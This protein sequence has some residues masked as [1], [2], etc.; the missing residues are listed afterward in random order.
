MRMNQVRCTGMLALALLG[1]SVSAKADSINVREMT[2]EYGDLNGDF[3]SVAPAA[4]PLPSVQHRRLSHCCRL[5]AQSNEGFFEDFSSVP[6]LQ[7]PHRLS[8]PSEPDALP[9]W[10][11]TRRNVPEPASSE[12]SVSVRP[13]FIDADEVWNEY[14]VSLNSEFDA[15]GGGS[16]GGQNVQGLGPLYGGSGIFGGYGYGF[17]LGSTDV[18]NGPSA[19]P[20]TKNAPLPLKNVPEPSSLALLAAGL[21]L[22]AMGLLILKRTE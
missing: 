14:G 18:Q 9:V 11:D 22:T 15:N 6:N 7:K 10:S 21:G 8:A 16:Y 12:R 17:P 20:V 4:K 2:N 5:G 1:L 3:E 13:D 19:K